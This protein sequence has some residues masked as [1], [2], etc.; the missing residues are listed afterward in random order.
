MYRFL[1]LGLLSGCAYAPN[2]ADTECDVD[3][4][5]VTTDHLIDCSAVAANVSQAR[6]ILTERSYLAAAEWSAFTKGLRIEYVN[7][8]CV[9]GPSWGLLPLP[10]CIYGDYGPSKVTLQVNYRIRLNADG[11]ALVH[12]LLHHL[13]AFRGIERDVMHEDWNENGYYAASADFVA[14]PVMA[15]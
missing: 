1:I 4:I 3:G 5:Q 10:G 11:G 7:Q 8:R 9:Y 12:E 14:L 15:P 6:S 2:A 13:D